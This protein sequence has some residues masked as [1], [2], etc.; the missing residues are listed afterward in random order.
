M[1]MI[2]D[3][4]EIHDHFSNVPYDLEI[5]SHTSKSLTGRSE[6]SWRLL[7]FRSKSLGI[8]EILEN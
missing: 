5:L 3:L 1:D 7:Q 8:P 2:K 6:Q 4:H